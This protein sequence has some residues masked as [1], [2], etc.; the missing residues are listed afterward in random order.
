MGYELVHR[1]AA[2]DYSDDMIGVHHVDMWLWIAW[3]ISSPLQKVH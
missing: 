3:A 2:A 1:T